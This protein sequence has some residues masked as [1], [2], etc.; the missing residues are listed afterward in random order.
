MGLVGKRLEDVLDG[1]VGEVDEGGPVDADNVS[2]SVPFVGVYMLVSMNV[3]W[4]C[5]GCQVFC[6]AK[7]AAAGHTFRIELIG[8]FMGNEDV[9]SGCLFKVLLGLL[10][11]VHDVGAALVAGAAFVAQDFDSVMF[12]GL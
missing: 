12:N 10:L 5:A 11:G 7:E 1:G 9:C 8:A 2:G 4:D 3:E 6:D